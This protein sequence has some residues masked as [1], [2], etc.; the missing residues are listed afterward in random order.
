LAAAGIGVGGMLLLALVS[1][2]PNVARYT[3][4]GLGGIGLALATGAD[5]GNV[6]GSVLANLAL[7]VALAALAWL[8]FRSQEL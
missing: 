8:T 6:I 4:G 5:A 2:L 7:V 1:V 3:P